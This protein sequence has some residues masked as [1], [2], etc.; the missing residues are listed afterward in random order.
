MGSDPYHPE[1][2]SREIAAIAPNATLVEQ[3]N[4]PAQDGTVARIIDFLEANTP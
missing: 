3:W 1:S 4:A 2:I